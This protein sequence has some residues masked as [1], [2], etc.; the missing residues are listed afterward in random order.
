MTENTTVIKLEP[1]QFKDLLIT[2]DYVTNQLK[3]IE[4]RL[5][6]IETELTRIANK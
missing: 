6:G 3:K 2:I 4:K 1:T 5:D